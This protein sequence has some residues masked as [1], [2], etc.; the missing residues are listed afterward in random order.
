[1]SAWHVAPRQSKIGQ[2]YARVKLYMCFRCMCFRG[3][4]VKG[5]THFYFMT[6]IEVWSIFKSCSVLFKLVKLVFCFYH[7]QRLKELATRA[8][9]GGLSVAGP[10]PKGSH[11]FSWWPCNS[12]L[13]T[14]TPQGTLP[15]P[16]LPHPD[17][18]ISF[19][20][21]PQGPRMS[22]CSFCLICTSCT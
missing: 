3:Q 20:R 14:P 9:K 12:C 22:L 16:H 13:P 21:L 11:A 19:E 6:T 4:T 15:F 17:E 18:P 10:C 1:M 5:L 8:A 2:P 7:S